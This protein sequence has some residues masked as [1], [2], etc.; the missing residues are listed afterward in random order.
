MLEEDWREVKVKVKRSNGCQMSK[1][2]SGLPRQRR[3]VDFP[4]PFAFSSRV[5]GNTRGRD[6][7]LLR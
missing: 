5:D 4:F 3:P 2:P 1:S 6:D 7:C